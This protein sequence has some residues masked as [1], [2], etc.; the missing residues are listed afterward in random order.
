MKRKRAEIVSVEIETWDA[1]RRSDCF[2]VAD[3]A[4][5]AIDVRMVA[6]GPPQQ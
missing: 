2:G 6:N 5:K 1:A 4:R 3:P